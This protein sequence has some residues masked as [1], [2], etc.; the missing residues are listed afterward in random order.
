MTDARPNRIVVLRALQLGDLLCSVPALRALRAFA[1]GAH[2]ALIGLPWAAELV[3][4]FD[5]YVDELIEFPGYPGIPERPATLDAV[6]PFF[7]AMANRGWDLAIQMQGNGTVTNEFVDRIGA[8]ATTGFTPVGASERPGF[9]VYPD[10]VPE[11]MRHLALMGRL[12]APADAVLD[13]RLELPIREDDR[14]AARGLVPASIGGYVVIHPGARD[15]RRRWPAARFAA[16]ADVVAALGYLPVI[17]GSTDE[18]T[19]AEEVLDTMTR[20]GVSIAGRTSL[21]S[22]AAVVADAALV[23]TNDT[24][25]S[26]VAAATATPSIVIFRAS[27]PA[28]W[29]PM[30]HRRHEAIAPEGI[31][32][33]W[34][35]TSC[36]HGGRHAGSAVAADGVLAAVRRRLAPVADAPLAAETPPGEELLGWIA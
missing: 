20:P 33:C 19:I 30:D 36:A 17:S 11:P 15:D 25:V 22:L 31:A 3:D 4:R 5:A 23:V 8:A 16:V 13:A 12:G 28:R 34:W 32:S 10:G 9:L 27:E 6:A 7:D 24:G 29:A 14:R 26:H 2:I 21:G 1:P 18:V 35:D